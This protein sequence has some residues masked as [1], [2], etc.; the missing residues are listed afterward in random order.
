MQGQKRGN[1]YRPM[2][3]E[4]KRSR[5]DN[6][7][8]M[9]FLVCSQVGGGIIGRG[10]STVKRLR[11]TYSAQIEIPDAKG[12]ERVL[13]FRAESNQALE[14]LKEL[15]PIMDQPPYP[16]NEVRGKAMVNEGEQ[17]E[18]NFLVHESQAGGIIGRG[19]EK[20]KEIR[21][22]SS[23][24]IKV[25]TEC[26]MDSTE[27]IVAIAGDVQSIVDCVEAILEVL[28]DSTIRGQVALYDPC[29]YDDFEAEYNQNH[30][31]GG[32]GGFPQGNFGGPQGNFGGNMMM[33][34]MGGQNFPQQGAN[35]GGPNR[36]NMMGGNNPAMGQQAQQQQGMQNNNTAAPG[37]NNDGP[38]ESTQ[39]TIPE[40]KAGCI[41]GKGGERLTNIRTKSGADVRMGDRGSGDRLITIC[42]THTQIQ[43]AQYL[44]Q[45]CVKQYGSA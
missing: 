30:P 32:P 33:G 24:R 16:G 35:F 31:V 26:L 7:V 43:H 23:A 8:T 2:D 28:K 20:I 13:S 37:T 12:P 15:V 17:Q 9:R 27:R 40:D 38:K 42:G 45:Q 21:E 19:G 18:V 41:I 3:D 29:I 44:M 5:D 11:D 10:G 14:L 22:R 39:V 34:Q 6:S 25:F 4:T 36:G 1:G